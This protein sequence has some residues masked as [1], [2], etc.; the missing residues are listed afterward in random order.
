[1]NPG[2]AGQ[3]ERVPKGN[4]L[5]PSQYCPSRDC[6][7]CTTNGAVFSVSKIIDVSMNIDE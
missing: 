6:F 7:F 1:M 3:E 4:T 5:L 2:R